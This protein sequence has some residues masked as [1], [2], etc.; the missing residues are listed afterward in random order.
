VLYR[1][2]VAAGLCLC[3]IKQKHNPDTIEQRYNTK[4]QQKHNPDTIEQRYNAKIQ[5]KHNPDT[6]EQR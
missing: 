5:Q 3:F 4:I 1:C 6:I 2:S